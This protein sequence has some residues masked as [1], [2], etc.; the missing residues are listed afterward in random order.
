M[1]NQINKNSP[2]W[3][4]ICS[5]IIG[6]MGAFSLF[7]SWTGFSGSFIGK[8]ITHL[9]SFLYE[10][11]LKWLYLILYCFSGYCSPF[12]YFVASPVFAG[13]IFLGIKSLKSSYRKVAILGVILCTI[14]LILALF[15]VL[16]LMRILAR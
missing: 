6:I 16:F 15:T 4:A 2:K 1:N 11:N 12:S 10:K 8:T 3:K 14:D 13:G 5:L 7:L 9:F